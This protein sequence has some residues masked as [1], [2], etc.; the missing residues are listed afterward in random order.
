MAL[1]FG[2]QRSNWRNKH[3]IYD[4]VNLPVLWWHRWLC[5][6]RMRDDS[7][8][9]CLG[10]KAVI[11]KAVPYCLLPQREGRWWVGTHNSRFPS[12][13]RVVW[14]RW[15]P[16]HLWHRI[17]LLWATLRAPYFPIWGS[18][19]KLGD[20]HS[21][22]CIYCWLHFFDDLGLVLECRFNLFVRKD[23]S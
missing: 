10:K 23:Q 16:L 20:Y 21:W 7:A 12:P 9:R 17:W 6:N 18:R 15:A 19:S 4:W 1:L 2:C 8:V 13:W 5:W 3:W 11:T 14:G 22:I